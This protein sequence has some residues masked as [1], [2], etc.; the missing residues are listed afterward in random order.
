MALLS[1]G[2][3]INQLDKIVFGLAALAG[4]S[5]TAIEV[6]PVASATSAESI[7]GFTGIIE[8]YYTISWPIF[9][10]ILVTR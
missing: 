4:V 10:G 8:Y 1:L 2:K 3:L 6:R 7:S 9:L 5:D